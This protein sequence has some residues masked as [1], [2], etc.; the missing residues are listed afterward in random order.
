MHRLLQEECRKLE[1]EGFGVI[2]A[3]DVNIA[4]SAI[5]GH[6]NLRTFPKQ[7]CLNRA[8][9]EA[10]FFA[11]RTD[12]ESDAKKGSTDGG[13]GMID[14][15]RY[16]HPDK[17]AYTFYPRTKT[18]GGSCDRVD[19][20]VMSQFLKDHLKQAGV[21]ETT[22]ERSLSDHVPLYAHLKFEDGSNK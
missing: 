20:I 8:D 4:R 18:F 13:L 10:K 9:F 22:S 6:P 17:K 5:D 7:H 21:H 2:I 11:G 16:L 3:G 12:Q 19:M 15:F 14:T 1:A